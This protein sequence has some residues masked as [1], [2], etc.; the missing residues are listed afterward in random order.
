MHFLCCLEC[1]F[2]VLLFIKHFFQ[3]FLLFVSLIRS[4][5]NNPGIVNPYSLGNKKLVIDGETE[6]FGEE[7]L[8]EECFGQHTYRD[9][10]GECHCLPNFNYGDPKSYLGC[11]RCYDECSSQGECS[12]PGRCVCNTGFKGDGIICKPIPVLETISPAVV[13]LKGATISIS[14]EGFNAS[15]IPSSAFCQI[16]TAVIA[17]RNITDR[18]FMCDAPATD[19]AGAVRLG[20]SFDGVLWSEKQEYLVFDKEASGVEIRGKVWILLAVGVVVG[21]GVY[22]CRLGPAEKKQR[23]KFE[24]EEE[25]LLQNV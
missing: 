14:F 1:R 9:P 18:S 23:V 4:S 5:E 21:C 3:M 24:G 13:P 22:I 16:G 8:P 6:I 17:G 12:F 11:W 15:F 10:S 20:I 7:E 19:T 2:I 25:K